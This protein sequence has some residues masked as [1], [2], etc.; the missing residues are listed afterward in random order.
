MTTSNRPEAF[1]ALVFAFVLFAIPVQ[2]ADAQR[3]LQT[4]QL[5]V[6]LTEMQ[7]N[8]PPRALMDTLTQVLTREDSIMVR[9]TPDGERMPI[10]DLKDELID[11]PAIG[12]ESANGMFVN[13]RFEIQ[14]RGFE[15]SIESLQYIYRPQGGNEEDIQMLYIDASDQ[16]IKD[17]LRNKGTTLETNQAALKT[18]KDQLAFA[19]MAKDG[20]VV[21]IAGETVR[22]GFEMEKRQLVQKIQRLTYES[23]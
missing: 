6:D 15:E 8:S 4:S 20:Q 19:R 2:Q 1:W 16:W 12:L 22:E 3:W 23:M 11:G 9:R 7:R 18:F 17:L 14:N 10:S 13:Y 21:Q 5:Y